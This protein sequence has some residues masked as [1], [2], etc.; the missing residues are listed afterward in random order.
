MWAAQIP[1]NDLK[2]CLLIVDLLSNVAALCTVCFDGVHLI[3][4]P[5]N[6][7]PFRAPSEFTEDALNALMV[8]LIF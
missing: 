3:V 4:K 1:Q 6:L 8:Y 7:K 2:A 5:K